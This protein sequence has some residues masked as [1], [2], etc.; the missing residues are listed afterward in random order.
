MNAETS[1]PAPA[2]R[3]ATREVNGTT[4]KLSTPEPVIA[5]LEYARANNLRLILTYGDAVTG[6][7]WEPSATPDTGCIGRSTGTEKIPLLIRTRRSLG[8]E[9]VLDDCIVQ[10]RT[11]KGKRLLYHHGMLEI[12]P[13]ALRTLRAAR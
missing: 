1:T 8:G 11:S 7:P 12:T 10:I 2:T 6:V 3:A 5:I 13:P 9:A 4:Y